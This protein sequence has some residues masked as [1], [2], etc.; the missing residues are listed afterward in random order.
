VGIEGEYQLVH[1][2][3][4]HIH[5]P[6]IDGKPGTLVCFAQRR[7]RFED[8]GIIAKE[9]HLC[10]SFSADETAFSALSSFQQSTICILISLVIDAVL[11]Y[12]CWM[13]YLRSW[14]I[15]CLPL[16]LWLSFLSSSIVL[17]YHYLTIIRSNDL[18]TALLAYATQT[19]NF[20][21]VIYSTN[22]ATN[23]YA[24]SAITYRI[25]R[26]ANLAN[27]SSAHILKIGRI[28]AESGILYTITSTIALVSE[29]INAQYKF[30]IFHYVTAITNVSMAGIAFN[31][32]LIRVGQNGAN[33]KGT[34]NGS[35]DPMKNEV[36]STHVQVT[37]GMSQE[38]GSA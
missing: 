18:E 29:A 15:I 28:L 2:H 17:T 36:I 25:L 19:Y 16:I 11:I 9:C 1:V 38:E 3:R 14:Y 5:I 24:T 35:Q 22:I 30:N 26:V 8:N 6:S 23:L 10:M 32:I 34:R 37:H 13:V 27:R 4:I 33:L 12:R 31:L 7:S 20:S 21:T